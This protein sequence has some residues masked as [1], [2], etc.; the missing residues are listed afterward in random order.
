MIKTNNTKRDIKPW[1]L[2]FLYYNK[3]HLPAS[4]YYRSTW[5]LSFQYVGI[6]LHCY[7]IKKWLNINKPL[8]YFIW[9]HNVCLYGLLVKFCLVPQFQVLQNQNPISMWYTTL[10]PSSLCV[11]AA[12]VLGDPIILC[13]GVASKECWPVI[14][15][16]SGIPFPGTSVTDPV[17][18]P[19]FCVWGRNQWFK[20]GSLH[21]HCRRRW[22]VTV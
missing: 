11:P 5:Y 3:S 13:L 22:T 12:R 1:S 20:G 19:V 9:K 21:S 16:L 4:I 10:K 2:I 8:K 7:T 14:G 6:V 15:R 17:C 18:G